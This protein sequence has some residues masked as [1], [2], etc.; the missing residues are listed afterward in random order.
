[1]GTPEAVTRQLNMEDGKQES[2]EY[3]RRFVAI[4]E[5]FLRFYDEAVKESEERRLKG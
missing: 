1:M 5:M 2:I 4:R 3:L